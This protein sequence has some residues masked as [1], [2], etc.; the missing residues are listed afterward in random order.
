MKLRL[1]FQ[2]AIFPQCDPA[3]LILDAP[4]HR[5]SPRPFSLY[6]GLKLLIEGPKKNV[7]QT[8]FILQVLRIIVVIQI[9]YFFL[10]SE[11]EKRITLIYMFKNNLYH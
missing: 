3:S 1:F 2:T 8:V 11:N 10:E 9:V 4:P 7:T 5:L 6:R